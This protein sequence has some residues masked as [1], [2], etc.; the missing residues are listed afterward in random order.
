MTDEQVDKI[1]RA[2][3]RLALT[4]GATILSQNIVDEDAIKATRAFWFDAI[5]QAFLNEPK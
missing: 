4:V 2:I 3:D 5:S 1:V